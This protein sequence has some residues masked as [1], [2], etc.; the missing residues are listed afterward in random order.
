MKWKRVLT[1]LLTAVIFFTGACF[2]PYFAAS[3]TVLSPAEALPAAIMDYSGFYGAVDWV[4]ERVNLLSFKYTR[5]DGGF[6]YTEKDPWQ[7]IFGFNSVFDMF[8]FLANAFYDTMRVKFEYGGKEWMVQFWKGSYGVCMFVG[9]EIGIYSKSLDKRVDHYD[10]AKDSECF[11]MSMTVY[12]KGERLFTRPLENYWWVNGFKPGYL[13]NFLR[14]P[15]TDCSL[16]STLVLPNAAMADA[17][18]AQLDA[19]GFLKQD[20]LTLA[21]A[22]A[23]SREGTKVHLLWQ[24]RHE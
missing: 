2:A 10:A 8:S 1:V 21:S 18:C 16:E 5:N 9:G 20:S 12:Q 13:K 11:P 15:R 22:D 23:Y 6:Y 3:D 7:R 14:T 17:F 4:L 19:K 24:Y